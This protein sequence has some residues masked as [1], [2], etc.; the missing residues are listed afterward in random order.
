MRWPG[1]VCQQGI[2]VSSSAAPRMSIL[3]RSGERANHKRLL[4]LL[5]VF[6]PFPSKA[7]S[8]HPEED[9]HAKNI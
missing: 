5:R 1:A 9:G 6:E 3:T 4:E 7:K 8:Y 2:P